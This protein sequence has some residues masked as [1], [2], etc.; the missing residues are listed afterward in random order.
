VQV[1][2]DYSKNK[3]LKAADEDENQEIKVYHIDDKDEN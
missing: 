2:F 3:E 1:V